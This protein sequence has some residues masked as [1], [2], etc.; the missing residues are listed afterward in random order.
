MVYQYRYKFYLNANHFVVIGGRKG[1]PHSHCF[2]LTIEIASVA[3]HETVA[4][5]SIERAIDALLMPYQNNL[6]NDIEPFNDIVP[7][8]ENICAYFK[9]E[10]SRILLEMNWV[11]MSIEVSETPSRSFVMTIDDIEF[12][13]SELYKNNKI[14]YR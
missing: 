11:L 10:I 8:L 4:F 13:K 2:E 5:E 3:G 12:A 9:D 1:A 6:L 14:Y 7:T